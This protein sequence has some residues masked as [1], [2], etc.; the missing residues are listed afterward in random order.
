[1]KTGKK[2]IGTLILP[3]ITLLA[4]WG[5][6]SARG[7]ALFETQLNTMTFV[8]AIAN[9]CLVTFAL[10]INL[11][12]GRFDFSVGS[13]ALLSSVVSARLAL[14]LDL[15]PLPMLLLS[16]VFGALF[17]LLSGAVYV[18]VKLPPII[19]SLAVALFYE[20]LAFTLTGGHGVSFANSAKLLSFSTIPNF[21]IIIAVTLVL[22]IVVFDHTKFG[23]EY[24]A[25]L[26]GQK[27]TVNTGVKEVP[28]ALICYTVAGALMGAQGF[29]SATTNGTIQMSLNFGSISPMFMAFLP[30]FIGGFIGRFSNDK[31]G[32]LLGAV[33]S[34]LI[35]LLY[36]R[37]N[38]SSSMQQ[39]TSA[40]L[41]V[42]FLI[43]L[44]NEGKLKGLFVRKE[45]KA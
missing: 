14:S 13:V 16:V 36:V 26:S 20:G 18:T 2:I 12:S 25:L 19:V 44:N 39:I 1:M 42:G 35:S 7:I 37:L 8:R 30:M 17:G 45:M 31:L 5:I 4:V 33:C 11:N 10:A 43:Y 41:L 9:V 15:G 34:A 29:I 40:L 22:M 3:L 32:Y 24:K 28:N 21:L 23:Y 38:V 27:V 6:C